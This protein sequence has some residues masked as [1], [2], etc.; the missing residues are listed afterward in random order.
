MSSATP[1]YSILDTGV[2]LLSLGCSGVVGLVAVVL[3]Y[4]VARNRARRRKQNDHET[5]MRSNRDRS[6]TSN[7]SPI[8]DTLTSSTRTLVEDEVYLSDAELRRRIE[9]LEARGTSVTTEG[10][11]DG[12]D[13]PSDKERSWSAASRLIALLTDLK[14]KVTRSGPDVRLGTG[15]DLELS[16]VEIRSARSARSNGTSSSLDTSRTQDIGSIEDEADFHSVSD[17]RPHRPKPDGAASPCFK[18]GEALRS[19]EDLGSFSLIAFRRDLQL[20]S[21][22]ED[23]GNTSSQGA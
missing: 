18:S 21:V 1:D 14:K 17:T 11:T 12:R 4:W 9:L 23:R 20:G 13:Q 22:G 5:I 16:T 3:G 2:L 10:E 15:T 7:M 8:A 6:R 19:S